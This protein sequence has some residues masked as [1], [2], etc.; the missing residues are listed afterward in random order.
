MRF[1]LLGVK[2]LRWIYQ[3]NLQ[4]LRAHREMILGGGLFGFLAGGNA[5]LP[6]LEMH[7][8]YIKE[9]LKATE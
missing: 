5:E 2:V 8:V 3:R 6:N 9:F 1:D 4:D 7:V